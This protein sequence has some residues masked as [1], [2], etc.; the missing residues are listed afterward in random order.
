M[1]ESLPPLDF[2]FV[3]DLR[4]RAGMTLEEVSKR[5][6]ISIG[7]LSKLE[8]NQNLVELETLY[9][10]GRVFG[11]SASDVLGLAENCS[12]HAKQ[13]ERYRSGPFDFTKISFQGI[14]CYQAFAK[15]GDSLMRP[16]A[17]GDD[18]EICWV[19]TGRIRIS[20]TR[21]T[22]ELGEGEALKF[23]AALHHTYEILEDA[24]LFIVH[25]T[26]THRF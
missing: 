14:E 10:L 21:E 16:E 6:G 20:F 12:A 9:R 2:S 11:L 26:K 24:E 23:D 19:Q 1:A 4:K 7:V 22:H 3:R 25:L 15:A 13:A 8:R 18:N 17:H 5:S